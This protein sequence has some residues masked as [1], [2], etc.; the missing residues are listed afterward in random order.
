MKKQDLV[1]STEGFPLIGWAV[2]WSAIGFTLPFAEFIKRLDKSD[3]NSNIARET[4]PKNAFLRAVRTSAKGKTT[5]SRK[6]K[7]GDG[8]AAS[9][10]LEESITS[11]LDYGVDQQST[12][13][14]DKLARDVTVTGKNQGEIKDSFEKFKQDYTAQQFR[15][16]VLRFVKRHCSGYMMKDGGGLYFIPA[17]REYE[18]N[19]LIKL[20]DL[21]GD[22]CELGMIP[23]VDTQLARKSMWQSFTVQT[24][25]E[26]QKLKDDLSELP[27]EIKE[28]SL[29]L[30]LKKYQ[31]LKTKVE[32]F[33]I[34]LEG[35]AKDMKKE[36]ADL[37]KT[38]KAKVLEEDKAPVKAKK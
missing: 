31:T 34:L 28:S 9:V 35:T 1:K 29:E 15:T 32:M 6:V 12:I 22:G 8:E 14:F 38:I 18:L 2:H 23:I 17:S 24:K 33:E 26:I 4:L 7:D 20:F 36:L 11:D 30:R 19:K 16:V 25:S 3:I 37:T 10:I 5:F 21:M 27:G 13:V